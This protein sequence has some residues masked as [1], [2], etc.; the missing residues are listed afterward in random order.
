MCATGAAACLLLTELFVRP[1][2]IMIDAYNVLLWL[3]LAKITCNAL[4]MRVG[5][6]TVNLC[7]FVTT[8]HAIYVARIVDALHVAI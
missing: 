7:G 8:Y 6:V 3:A 2:G 1:Y 5:C 4:A